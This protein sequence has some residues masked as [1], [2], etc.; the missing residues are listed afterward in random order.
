MHAMSLNLDQKVG[1]SMQ[2]EKAVVVAVCQIAG[3]QPAIAGEHISGGIRI[4]PVA[5]HHIVSASA[6]H[7]DGAR[8]HLAHRFVQDSEFNT[9]YRSAD[10]PATKMKLLSRQRCKTGGCFRLA[11]HYEK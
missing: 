9:R 3:P 2:I 4:I 11:V 1:T 7:A 6:E 5:E 8:R 10:R